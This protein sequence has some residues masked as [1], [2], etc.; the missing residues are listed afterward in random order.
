MF[1]PRVSFNGSFAP[2]SIVVQELF[3]CLNVPGGDEDEVGHPIDVVQ[4]GLTVATLAVVDEPPQAVRFLR[5][6]DTERARTGHGVAPG[7]GARL[8]TKPKV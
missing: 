4:L 2:V 5:S 1:Q 8:G 6:V 7:T 3:T